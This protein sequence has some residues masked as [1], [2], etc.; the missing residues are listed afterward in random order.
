MNISK[1]GFELIKKH[2]ACASKIPNVNFQKQIYGFEGSTLNW[3]EI[4]AIKAE[5]EKNIKVYPYY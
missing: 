4:L 3:S 5:Q 1:E 2:E